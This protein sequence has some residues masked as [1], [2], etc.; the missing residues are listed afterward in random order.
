[1]IIEAPE[2][3]GVEALNADRVVV[4]LALKTAPLEQWRVSRELRERIKAAGDKD[5]RKRLERE[6]ADRHP[7]T[8]RAAPAPPP[9]ADSRLAVPHDGPAL[10]GTRAIALA[11]VAILLVAV[12]LVLARLL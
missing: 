1:V 10:W 2:V 4:R 8:R 6:L 5:E 3:W 12:V 7:P 11:M 9:H